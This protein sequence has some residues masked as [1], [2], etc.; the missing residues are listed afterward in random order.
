MLRVEPTIR[1]GK[2][3]AFSIKGADADRVSPKANAHHAR[4][5]RDVAALE[6]NLN[7]SQLVVGIVCF[8][9]AAK[10]LLWAFLKLWLFEK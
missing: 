10:L 1:C 6:S 2:H 7:G 8:L 3:I 5:V 9:G 4:S